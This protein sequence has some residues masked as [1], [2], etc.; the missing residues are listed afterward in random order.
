MANQIEEN[1]QD[2]EKSKTVGPIRGL[3]PFLRPYRALVIMA[4][5]ALVLTAGLSL[6]LPLAVRRVIDSF[7]NGSTELLDIYFA[8]AVGVAALLALGT[9]LRYYLVTRLGERVVADIRKAVYDRMIGMSPAFFERIMTGEVLSRITTDT[10]LILSVIGSSVSVALRNLLIFVGGLG[11]MLA[12]S[13]KLA[14]LV[15]V[16]VPVVVVPILVLGRRLR[17]LSR[18]NQDKIAESS[19]NA[20]ETLQ[21]A[22]TVQAFS[23]ETHSRQ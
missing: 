4:G 21:A 17:G 15:L 3:F 19:G 9:G 5:F 8:A 11:F 14:L 20:S 1:T 10:T 7:S 2:R 6:A 16:I 13:L 18:E 23:H 12:T 22:Q